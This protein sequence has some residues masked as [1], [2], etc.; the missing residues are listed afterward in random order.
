MNKVEGI[1]VVYVAGPYRAATRMQ[2]HQNIRRAEEVGAA[3][4]A[5]GAMPIIPHANTAFMDGSV[6]DEHFLNG[7]MAILRRCD[8]IVLIPGWMGSE[9]TRNELRFANLNDIPDF[10]WK[11]ERSKFERWMRGWVNARTEGVEA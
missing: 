7:D 1:P 3:V 9:G 8:A 6:P 10:N 4:M 5:L 2:V 11:W